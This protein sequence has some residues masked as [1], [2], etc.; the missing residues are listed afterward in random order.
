MEVITASCKDVF[1]RVTA[2]SWKG[3]PESHLDFEVWYKHLLRKAMFR[4]TIGLASFSSD[5][6]GHTHPPVRKA[7]G[8]KHCLCILPDLPAQAP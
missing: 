1:L 4:E 6:Q 5:P 7:A 2:A 3:D 8:L